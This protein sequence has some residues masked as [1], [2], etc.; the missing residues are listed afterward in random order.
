MILYNITSQIVP[1]MESQW[2]EWMQK[3]H[4]PNQ[5]AT[6]CFVKATLLKIDADTVDFKAYAVQ[7]EMVS[8]KELERYKTTIAPQIAEQLKA[9]FGENVLQ[10]STQ[11][12]MISTHE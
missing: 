1:E 8:E 10:F 11:L 4:L 6:G 12:Q 2:M 3:A 9:V 7:Y 5:M